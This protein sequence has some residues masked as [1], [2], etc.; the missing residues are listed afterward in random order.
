MYDINVLLPRRPPAAASENS[1]L[2]REQLI[3]EEYLRIVD[4]MNL[5][6]PRCPQLQLL[7]NSIFVYRTVYSRT[8][9]SEQCI[10]Y[11]HAFFSHPLSLP[12]AHTH[13]L[14]LSLSHTHTHPHT[15]THQTPPSCRSTRAVVIRLENNIFGL[16]A[17]IHLISFVASY[18]FS[19][20]RTLLA[21]DEDAWWYAGV[22]VCVCVR[23]CVCVCVCVCV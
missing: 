15:H 4:N 19:T 7:E 23:V 14:S 6:M 8:T 18:A 2:S 10:M 21:A 13:T 1:I 11:M 5:F 22:C 3:R 12:H 16:G 17:Q 9:D 20:G